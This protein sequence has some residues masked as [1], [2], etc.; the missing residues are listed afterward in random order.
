MFDI[1]RS[2]ESMIFKLGHLIKY[3][4]G[5]IFVVKYGEIAHQKSQSSTQ[6]WWIVENIA[7]ENIADTFKKLVC[8]GEKK[9]IKNCQ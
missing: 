1:L 9:I 3:Y 4:I 7:N 2:E 6:F 5:K 8:K